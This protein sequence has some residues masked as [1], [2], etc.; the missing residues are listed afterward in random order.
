MNIIIELTQGIHLG[1][2]DSVIGKNYKERK[3]EQKGRKLKK[4]LCICVQI[5]VW[6]RSIFFGVRQSKRNW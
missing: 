3:K 5:G 6:K 1:E 2:T 4:K